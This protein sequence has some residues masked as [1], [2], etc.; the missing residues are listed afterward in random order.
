MSM[1]NPAD[2]VE[3]ITAAPRQCPQRR[4]EGGAPCGKVAPH[5]VPFSGGIISAITLPEP[6]RCDHALAARLA[7]SGR[8]F[9]CHA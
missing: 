6:L 8:G 5:A 9:Q 1:T 2:R 7:P 3:I 4:R